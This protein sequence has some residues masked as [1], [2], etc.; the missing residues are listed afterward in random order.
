MNFVDSR[1]NEIY[2]FVE[3]ILNNLRPKTQGSNEGRNQ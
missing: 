2:M 1:F 3:E